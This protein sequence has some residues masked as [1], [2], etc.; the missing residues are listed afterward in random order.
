MDAEELYKKIK[1]YFP[2]NLDLMQTEAIAE[3]E[4]FNIEGD[5]IVPE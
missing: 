1:T 3:F 2:N 5:E 4:A